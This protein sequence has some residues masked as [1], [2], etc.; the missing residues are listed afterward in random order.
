MAALTDEVKRFAVQALACYDTPSQVQKSIK[1]EFGL[2]V[3]RQQL[4]AYDPKT[5]AGERMSKKLKDL[6]AAT[7]TAFLDDVSTI[8]IAQQAFRLRSLQRLH[9]RAVQQ[10]NAVVAAQLLEQASKEIGGAF[11]N[12]RELT[13]KDGK[14][15][16]VAPAGVLVVPG[17]MQ[18]TAAWA[19]QAQASSL[20][21]GE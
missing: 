20:K 1:E 2:E 8:P 11:T 12:R 4:Q 7:R 17:L 5:V 9:E 21:P 13:G 3:T 18:D 16:P 15:L 10:G 6:F 14:D 19:A